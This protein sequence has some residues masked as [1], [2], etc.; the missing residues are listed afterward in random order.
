L[1]KA[2]LG[3]ALC[4]YR[5]DNAELALS[6]FEY[7]LT[8]DPQDT[9]AIDGKRLALA[10]KK[11]LDETAIRFSE[12]DVK[13]RPKASGA[14]ASLGTACFRARKFEATAR[15]CD[16]ALDL[17]PNHLDARLLRGRAR[18]QQGDRTGALEDWGRLCDATP[19]W[20]VEA[21]RLR[22]LLRAELGDARGAIEDL[23][24]YLAL[25]P[26]PTE[27]RA[28]VTAKLAAIKAQSGQ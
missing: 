22:G 20:C 13:E 9:V 25:E 14:W 4:A 19:V 2:R 21:L 12:A 18:A 27:H 6:D 28:P 7:L 17:N 3:R 24:R 1:T 11:V 26:P 5:R 23:E 10:K 8:A 15:A 16:R